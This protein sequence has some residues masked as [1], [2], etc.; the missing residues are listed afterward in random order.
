VIGRSRKPAHRDVVDVIVD[1]RRVL[2]ETRPDQCPDVA[3]EYLCELFEGSAT[4]L[5]LMDYSK[6]RFHTIRNVGALVP[7]ERSHPVGE[8]YAFGDFPYSAQ[9]LGRGAA[10]R[11][12]VDDPLC[13]PE[14]RELLGG[15]RRTDCLGAPIRHQGRAFG[16]L[17]VSR[18]SG[19]PF[20]DADEDLAVACGA[21]LARFFRPAWAVAS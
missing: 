18:D 21:T 11:A 10:Y 17:W 8:Y 1:F 16:E 20:T 12:S 5:N 9:Q 14:Y 6:V 3:A 7:R 19:R 4:A 2:A 13:A 15:M